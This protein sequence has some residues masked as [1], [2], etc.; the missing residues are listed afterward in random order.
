MDQ[1]VVDVSKVSGVELGA[2]VTIL[3]EDK[4]EKITADQLASFAQ[5]IS[6]EILCNLGNR[7]PRIYS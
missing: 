7:L 5:T 4:G 1:I 2:R 3:G 6:Y